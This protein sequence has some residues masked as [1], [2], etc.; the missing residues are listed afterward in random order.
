[1]AAILENSLGMQS[2]TTII[3]SLCVSAIFMIFLVKRAH[4]L[5]KLRK[6]PS[7]VALPIIGNAVQLNCDLEG[8]F[9]NLLFL[10]FFEIFFNFLF[11]V[12]NLNIKIKLFS[13][14]TILLKIVLIK[15]FLKA[16]L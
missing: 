12:I 8:E 15:S 11:N 10:Y 2:W 13:K 7:P 16:L 6:V 3:L 14:N 1:M 9:C 4:F 5:Y